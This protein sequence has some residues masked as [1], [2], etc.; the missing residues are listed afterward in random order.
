MLRPA[1]IEDVF[2][3]APRLRSADRVELAAQGYADVEIAL[4][5]SIVL[6]EE[7]WAFDHGGQ[8]H[9][10]GG[11]VA[12][13]CGVPW[14]LGSDELF[15]HKK[16]LMTVPLHYIP[17]W[18]ERFGLLMNMVHAENHQSIRWLQ[19]IGFTIHPAV[20]FGSGLFHPFTMRQP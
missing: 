10:V 1:N 12:A 8:V 16:A 13:E 5:E 3:L 6:S 11:V 7:V 17:R 2:A 20:P 14:M 4:A 19:R 18:L 9:A 15:T